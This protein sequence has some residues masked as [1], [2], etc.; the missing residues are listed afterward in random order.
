[1]LDWLTHEQWTTGAHARDN[2][3]NERD[4]DMQ[5]DINNYLSPNSPKAVSWDLYGALRISYVNHEDFYDAI[6]E[7][8]RVFKIVFPEK[9][10]ELESKRY[11]KRDGQMHFTDPS[12][13]ELNDSLES[14][15]QVQ[16]LLFYVN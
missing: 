9:W 10:A 8:K 13:F 3:G 4:S 5:G 15:R 7:L 1:M 6:K 2:L 12:L 14:Y 16:R 11:Y